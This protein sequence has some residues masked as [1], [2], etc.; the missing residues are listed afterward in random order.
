MR[1]GGFKIL[2][3]PRPP[4]REATHREPYGREIDSRVQPPSAVEAHFLWIELVEIMEHA[5]DGVTLV[6]VKGML[7]DP[8]DW[9]VGVE[10]QGFADPAAGVRE[11]VMKLFV[12]RKQQH[13]RRLRAIGANDHGFG[14]LQMR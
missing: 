8:K 10:H 9:R 1:E 3:P 12:C 7:V 5:A 4:R 11:P 14:L 2:P 13:P 6:F